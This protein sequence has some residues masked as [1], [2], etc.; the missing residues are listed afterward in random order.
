MI[1]NHQKFI[2]HCSV[3]SL[4]LLCRCTVSQTRSHGTKA[5]HLTDVTS[6]CTNF[7][8][9]TPGCIQLR[10]NQYIS[11]DLPQLLKGNIPMTACP[12]S[13][14]F[15]SKAASR[16]AYI[17]S[18]HSA[19]RRMFILTIES[20]IPV[21]RRLLSLSAHSCHIWHW[22]ERQYHKRRSCVERVP[23]TPTVCFFFNQGNYPVQIPHATA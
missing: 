22:V 20:V 15:D 4:S 18:V 13:A 6:L 9:S 2:Q 1:N 17:T 10:I 11:V 23:S 14:S 3:P 7:G 16:T 8:S 5:K 21:T 12:I 19:K